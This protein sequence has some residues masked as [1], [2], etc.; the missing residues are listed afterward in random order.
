[1]NEY[2]PH[3][4]RSLPFANTIFIG[5]G[6]TD[7]PCMRPVRDQGGHSIAA[8]QPGSRTKKAQA[9]TLMRDETI[10][11]CLGGDRRRVPLKAPT[12]ES[13]VVKEPRGCDTRR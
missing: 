12:T 13:K 10:L 9:E 4:D 8:Y 1:M 5:G 7:V 3:E 6:E 2:M 11:T